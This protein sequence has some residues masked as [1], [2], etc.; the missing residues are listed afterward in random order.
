[1]RIR[2]VLILWFGGI[3]LRGRIVCRFMDRGL[4]KLFLKSSPE[5]EETVISNLGEVRAF[6]HK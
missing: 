4:F 5:V 6:M 2:F 1:V 3:R